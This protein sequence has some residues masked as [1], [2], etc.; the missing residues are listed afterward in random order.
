MK[1][2]FCPSGT[3]SCS[4]SEVHC[5]APAGYCDGI[6]NDCP[7]NLDEQYCNAECGIAPIP[8]D[9]NLTRIVGGAEAVPHSWPWQVAFLSSSGSQFCGGSL[10]SNR[11]VMTAAH[12]CAGR[13]ISNSKV[14]LGGHSYANPP[15]GSKIHALRRIIMHPTYGSSPATRYDFCLLELDEP[16]QFGRTIVPVCLPSVADGGAG[17]KCYVTGWGNTGPRRALG[18]TEYMRLIEA[19]D[20]GK[21]PKNVAATLRGTSVLHQVDVNISEQSYCNT[22][23]NGVIDDSMVCAAA[24]G[25]DTCQGDSGGPLVCDRADGQPGFVLVGVTSWGRG[26]AQPSYPGVYGRTA[27]A[28]DWITETMYS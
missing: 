22:Q 19:L 12:C 13:T 20:G 4:N 15:E 3:S 23:Y 25:K 2:E 11:W 9:L 6:P 14:L 16:A 21:L 18:S 17:S 1:V 8:P 26:C 24:P 5:I 27:H 10:V 28:L 7:H